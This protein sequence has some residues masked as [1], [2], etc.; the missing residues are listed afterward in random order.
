MNVDKIQT[1]DK[2][3]PASVPALDDYDGHSADW[4][5]AEYRAQLPVPNVIAGFWEGEPGWVDLNFW[6]YNELCV[7]LTGRVAVED[8]NGGRVEYGPG[9]SFL[10]PQG[11]EGR[12]VTIEPT[13]KIFVG[14]DLDES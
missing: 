6:P 3:L 8:R 14:V 5:E 7:I 4:R 13:T 9:E 1:L 10:V 11:F 12:W 2:R